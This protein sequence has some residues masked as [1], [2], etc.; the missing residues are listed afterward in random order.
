[1]VTH[2]IEYITIGGVVLGT[3]RQGGADFH[4]VENSAR[5]LHRMSKNSR[6]TA[7]TVHRVDKIGATSATNAEGKH[8]RRSMCG[9][10][11][12]KA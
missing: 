11:Y 7:R 2:P 1:M 12:E 9:I 8:E 3:V 4:F 10:V 5:K 6:G